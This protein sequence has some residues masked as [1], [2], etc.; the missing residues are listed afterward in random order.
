MARHRH[1]L[2]VNFTFT[3]VLAGE[4]REISRGDSE[5]LHKGWRVLNLGAIRLLEPGFQREIDETGT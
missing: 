2:Y 5:T 4:Q 3:I 1:P